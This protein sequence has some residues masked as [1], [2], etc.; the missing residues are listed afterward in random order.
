ME[1][2]V[3][4][5][6]ECVDTSWWNSVLIGALWWRDSVGDVILWVIS[7]KSFRYL[8][9]VWYVPMSLMSSMRQDV[10][11][12]NVIQNKLYI[13]YMLCEYL[14]FWLPELRNHYGDLTWDTMQYKNS[15][16][17]IHRHVT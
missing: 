11:T 15:Q 9:E 4:F 10:D 14:V 12:V 2:E 6:M 1:G 13:M 17:A 3:L 7:F 16:K 5:E 8:E